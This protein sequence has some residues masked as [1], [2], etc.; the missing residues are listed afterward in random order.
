MLKYLKSEEQ[1]L[2]YNT[3]EFEKTQTIKALAIKILMEELPHAILQM[4]VIGYSGNIKSC[5]GDMSADNSVLVASICIAFFTAILSCIMN[6]SD[7]IYRERN[8]LAILSDVYL[9]T[10]KEVIK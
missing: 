4:F 2:S 9:E 1:D 6:V 7:Y 10:D 8:F 3:W 5:Q